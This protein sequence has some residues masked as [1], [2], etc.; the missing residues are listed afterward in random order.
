MVAADRERS[1]ASIHEPNN[2][3]FNVFVACLQIETA[4][5]R[6]VANV[7]NLQFMHRSASE[8]VVVGADAFN[9]T[10]RARTET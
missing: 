10:E 3:P 1:D 9:R 5:E 7:R 8:S 2:E 4:P 6:H